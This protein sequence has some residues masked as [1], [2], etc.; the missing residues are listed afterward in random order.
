MNN[1]DI[2]RLMHIRRYCEDIADFI[3]R[4]GR[5]YD[6]FIND[7]AYSNAVAMCVLQIGELANSLS[8]EFRGETEDQMPWA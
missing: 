2:Q 4:F 8:P 1:G 7:R 5:D 6:T 3:G